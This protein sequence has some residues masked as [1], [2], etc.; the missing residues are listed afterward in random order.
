MRN[1]YRDAKA[2]TKEK[3]LPRRIARAFANSS[4]K[5]RQSVLHDENRSER[6]VT[7]NDRDA[8]N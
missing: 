2:Q 5:K 1:F 6:R 7:R 4:K 3:L 8:T